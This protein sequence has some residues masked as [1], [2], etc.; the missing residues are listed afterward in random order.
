MLNQNEQLWLSP[1]QV[2]EKYNLKIDTLKK[3]RYLK[4]GLPHVRIGKLIR[5]N[6]LQIKQYLEENGSLTK[7]KGRLSENN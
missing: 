3:Q 7:I 2:A 5:Y 4:K 6:D 1:K